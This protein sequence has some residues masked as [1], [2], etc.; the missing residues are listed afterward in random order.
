MVFYMKTNCFLKVVTAAVIVIVLVVA[1]IYFSNGGDKNG[2]LSLSGDTPD[3]RSGEEEIIYVT[4]QPADEFRR[5][6]ASEF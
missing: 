2:D 4:N 6:T 5:N 1:L 3:G